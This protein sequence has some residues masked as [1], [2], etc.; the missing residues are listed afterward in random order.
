MHRHG[1][2]MQDLTHIESEA[3]IAKILARLSFKKS[4]IYL[5]QTPETIQ[6]IGMRSRFYKFDFENGDLEF[7]P[8][9]GEFEF[10]G[11]LP[12]YFYS[13]RKTIIFKSFTKYNSHHKI[14]LSSPKKI[15]LNNSRL[16]PREDLSNKN[17]FIRYGHYLN[18]KTSY[19]YYPMKSRVLD[20]SQKGLSIQTSMNTILKYHVGD[21]IR[22]QTDNGMPATGKIKYVTKQKDWRTKEEFFKVGLEFQEMSQSISFL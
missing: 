3:Q 11:R 19:E 1:G 16:N 18:A 4:L 7:F 22:V 20:I 5:W 21:F 8:Y 6:R 12:I 13:K 10:N 17:T 2:W 14:V 9:E 15:I